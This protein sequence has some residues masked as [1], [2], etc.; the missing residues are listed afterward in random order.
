[1]KRLDSI[2]LKICTLSVFIT[3]TSAG[4][5]LGFTFLYEEELSKELQKD[6]F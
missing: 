3:G 5:E 1:M 2:L 4:L 6:F